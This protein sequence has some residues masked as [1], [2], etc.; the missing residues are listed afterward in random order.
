MVSPDTAIVYTLPISV[1]TYTIPIYVLVIF[2]IAVIIHYDKG[3]LES[4]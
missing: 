1:Y 2:S 4:I 3:N